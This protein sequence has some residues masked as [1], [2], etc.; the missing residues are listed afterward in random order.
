MA[1]LIDLDDSGVL[2]PQEGEALHSRHRGAVRYKVSDNPD[3]STTYRI[4]ATVGPLHYSPDRNVLDYEADV[5][6]ATPWEPIDLDLLPVT[7]KGWQWGMEANGYQVRIWTRYGL[8]APYAARF[9]RGG[10]WVQLA[11]LELRYENAAG[12][13]QTISKPVTGLRPTIDNEAHTCRWVDAFGPGL[14]WQYNLSPDRF[15]K[16]VTVDSLDALPVPTIGEEGLRLTV[17]VALAWSGQAD[18]GF[19][20][21]TDVSVLASSEPTAEPEEDVI[22]WSAFAV[23]RPEDA[24]AALWM[25]EPRSWDAEGTDIPMR[26]QLR[27]YGSRMVGAFS[28][29]V[30]DLAQVAAWPVCVDTA[31]TEEQVG[32]SN[33]DVWMYGIQGTQFLLS[34]DEARV[35]YYDA[36]NYRATVGQRFTT[37]PIAQGST[38][39]TAALSVKASGNWTS[40]N[41]KARLRCEN[42]DNAAVFSTRANW[43]GRFP[44]GATATV[45]WDFGS[46]TSGSW[47]QSPDI[48]SCVGTVIARAGWTS[49]NALVIF[50]DDNDDRSAHTSENVRRFWLW[51]YTGNVSGPKFNAT[52]TAGGAATGLPMDLFLPQYHGLAGLEVF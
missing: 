51:D 22:D 36:S 38:I 5:D 49:D 2:Q 25:H 17:L 31:I 42:T 21:E 23:L 41:C 4:G 16:T 50:L 8:W 15:F 40:A 35:G 9:L 29:A 28:V 12:E 45:D 26:Y 47:V 48:A 24:R 1:S 13:K 52:Y 27:R 18:N 3:G 20:G 46:W 37:I 6:E 43:D 14:H 19:G 32:A 7:G 33:N 30:D 44:T 34:N 11:P 10:E 39:D